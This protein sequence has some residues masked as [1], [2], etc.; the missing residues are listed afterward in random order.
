MGTLRT[1][2]ATAEYAAFKDAGGLNGPCP[3]CVAPAI[4][5]FKHWKIMANRFPYDK[6]A[7]THD[8]VVSLRHADWADS[9]LEERAELDE[10]KKGYINDHYDF[11]IEAT[12]KK[13]SIP[14]HY[15]LHLIVATD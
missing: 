13:K 6:V 10:I 11:I 4:A 8:M 1:K 3:L 15:H 2:A 9:T 12:T 5:E 14:P 7:V